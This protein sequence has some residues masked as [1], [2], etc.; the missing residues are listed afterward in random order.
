MQPRPARDDD[1]I[2][3]ALG[4]AGRRLAK[5]ERQWL[6]APFQAPMEDHVEIGLADG[7]RTTGQAEVLR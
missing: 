2:E 5:G 7:I 4:P 6:A 1:V 3:E